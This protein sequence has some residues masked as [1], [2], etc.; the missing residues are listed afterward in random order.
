[1]WTPNSLI[2][3]AI[4]ELELSA[5]SFRLLGELESTRLHSAITSHFLTV[6]NA[7]FWWEVLSLPYHSWSPD[8]DAFKQVPLIVP[9]P[10]ER[11]W[12]VPQ[13][14]PEKPIFETS[15]TTAIRVIGECAAFEY[16]ICSKTLEWMIIENHHDC[17]IAVGREVIERMTR[18]EESA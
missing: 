2:T 4:A 10:E 5:E 3:A 17:I 11:I 16:A 15:T 12:F 14:A 7:L 1:M 6:E 9:D 13:D 8:S 18:L